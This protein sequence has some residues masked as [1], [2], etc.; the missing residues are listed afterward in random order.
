MSQTR[1]KRANYYLVLLFWVPLLI[2]LRHQPIELLNTPYTIDSYSD[3][4]SEV[5][6]RNA[7]H[8]NLDLSFRIGEKSEEK[9]AGI[10]LDFINGE[11]D[12]SPYNRL[13]CTFDSIQT[14]GVNIIFETVSPHFTTADHSLSYRFLEHPVEL[15]SSSTKVSLKLSLFTT[16]VWW[17]EHH[18]S[19]PHALGKE[20]LEQVRGI[21]IENCPFSY[22]CSVQSIR[23]VSLK[24]HYDRSLLLA[25]TIL[26]TILSL[27]LI[28]IY[29][30]K[31]IVF[32]PYEK[33]D[34]ERRGNNDLETVINLISRQYK[35]RGLSL[36]DISVQTA[37]PTTHISNLFNTRFKC[38]YRQ[39]L[40]MLRMI[41][42]QR[43]LKESEF[44][45]SEIAFHVGYSNTTHFNRI[46]KEFAKTTP[47]H[48]RTENI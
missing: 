4:L 38:T 21:K 23:L 36:S 17:Y 10:T 45:V 37:I 15:D 33:I 2:S 11:Q 13:T 34:E 40:N 9:Y 32:I 31:R 19:S 48:F 20:S 6:V 18:N 3:T 8:H 44:S 5:T 14:D 16:P 29:T 27:L 12:F 47:T 22:S 43:L 7:H 46:F 24:I 39:Y 30:Q 25:I 1:G 41:E 42:A 35:K 26:L 28:Y